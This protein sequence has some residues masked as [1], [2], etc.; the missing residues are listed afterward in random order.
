[1]RRAGI[2]QVR[3]AELDA[4]ALERRAAQ[5]ERESWERDELRDAVRNLQSPVPEDSPNPDQ[6]AAPPTDPEV[7][8][9][10]PDIDR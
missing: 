7:P 10:R 2:R 1:L 5:R 6:D 4:E 3:L 8:D 9:S